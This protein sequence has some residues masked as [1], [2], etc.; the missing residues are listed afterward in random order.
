MAFLS[1]PL[2][3]GLLLNKWHHFWPWQHRSVMKDYKQACVCFWHG[4]S[5]HKKHVRVYKLRTCLC[6]R[7]SVLTRGEE[8]P[9]G[10]HDMP[11]RTVQSQASCT[12]LFLSRFIP[13]PCRS[14]SASTQQVAQTPPSL[15]THSIREGSRW[16]GI[17]HLL[18]QRRLQ[19]SHLLGPEQCD[20]VW[21]CDHK[22]S[23]FPSGGNTREAFSYRSRLSRVPG[24][25]HDIP[26]LLSRF[27]CALCCL[28]YPSLPLPFLCPSNL[29]L[30]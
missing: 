20:T 6:P 28:G 5:N 23:P 13:S 1:L 26:H 18:L 4:F 10:L 7:G 11:L 3:E 16:W 27:S 14:A 30:S 17:E 15:H 9:R 12:A 2:V 8:A 29:I 21:G 19:N 25:W 22:P 24:P